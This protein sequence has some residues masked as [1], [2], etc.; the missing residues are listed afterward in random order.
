MFTVRNF[1]WFWFWNQNRNTGYKIVPL[2]NMLKTA[3]AQYSQKTCTHDISAITN[4]GDVPQST[5]F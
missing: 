5:N 3:K 1:W 2:N 4:Q